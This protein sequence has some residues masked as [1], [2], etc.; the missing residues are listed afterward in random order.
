MMY[1]LS[2]DELKFIMIDPKMVELAQYND[3]PYLLSPVVTNPK[4]AAATLNWVVTEMENRYKLFAE[5]GVRNIQS[6]NEK[7]KKQLDEDIDEESK[8]NIEIDLEDDIYE[9]YDVEVED[10]EDYDDSLDEEE[11]DSDDTDKYPTSLPYIVVVVD[12]LA[13]LMMIAAD[14]V[15]TAIARLAQLARATGIHLILATQR[16]SVDVITGVIKSNFPARVAFKVS[17]QIDSRT[18][19]DTKGADKLIG[20]GDM[21]F[22][23][24]SK[25]KPIRGQG[26]LISDDEINRIVA[27][28]KNK[29]RLSIIRQ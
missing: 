7:M 23:D 21:L 24:P 10:E 8:D 25:E 5:L 18:V 26:T 29:V 16:P 9:E 19:L 3:I 22:L 11:N 4:K 14:K 1:Y 28:I 27:F 13:D 2:P 20:R 17:S 12:E 15:E 6:Y